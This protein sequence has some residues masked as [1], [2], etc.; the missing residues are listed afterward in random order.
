MMGTPKQSLLFTILVE[1]P[2]GSM[3]LRASVGGGTS[4]GGKFLNQTLNDAL[5]GPALE[6]VYRRE[7]SAPKVA[8]QECTVTILYGAPVD[9]SKARAYKAKHPPPCYPHAGS[10]RR[11][12]LLAAE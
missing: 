12:P 3:T 4:V 10:S 6:D 2:D 11:V 8:A 9:G 1:L 7:P 5:I